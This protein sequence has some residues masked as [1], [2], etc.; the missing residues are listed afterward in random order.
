MPNSKYQLKVDVM[1]IGKQS[2][3]LHQM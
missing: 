1:V 2:C 3:P